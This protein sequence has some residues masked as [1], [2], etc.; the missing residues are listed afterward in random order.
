MTSSDWMVQSRVPVRDKEHQTEMS[1]TSL[2]QARPAVTRRGGSER[3]A[4]AK[5]VMHSTGERLPKL[6]VG[7]TSTNHPEPTRR[8]PPGTT[9][10]RWHR[11]IHARVFCFP[12]AKLDRAP[13]EQRDTRC[14]GPGSKAAGKEQS[15]RLEI[16]DLRATGNARPQF[17]GDP[18]GKSVGS[19][20]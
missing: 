13:K 2:V 10:W 11:T 7:N 19:L 9:R 8:E 20:L 5:A 18:T 16:S 15:L 14:F 6:V 1:H 3:I 17:K 4:A 12:K